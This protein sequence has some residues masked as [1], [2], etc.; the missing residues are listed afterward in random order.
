MTTKEVETR[1]NAEHFY[2]DKISKSKGIF[3][4]KQSYFFHFGQ[5]SQKL[6]EDVKKIFG[7]EIQI[8]ETRDD[9]ESWPKTSYLVVKFKFS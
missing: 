8:F 7:K 3:T 6:A 5:T 4:I 1:M 2:P 9:F